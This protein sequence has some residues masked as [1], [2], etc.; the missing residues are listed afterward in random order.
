MKHIFL[1][2]VVYQ[3]YY[4]DIYHHYDRGDRY[5]C[6]SFQDFDSYKNHMQYDDI[7]DYEVTILP[8]IKSKQTDK[9]M[10]EINND[11]RQILTGDYIQID[12]EE[13]LIQKIVYRENG[14]I[15][16][17]TNKTEI[18][19]DKDSLKTCRMIAYEFIKEKKQYEEK[20]KQEI[21]KKKWYQFWKD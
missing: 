16:Y 6:V 17:Y 15:V 3:K 4:V 2:D 14:D 20:L 18:I 9:V 19:K 7:S 8:H 13:S 5:Y 12:N 1:G 21:N 10:K 11:M